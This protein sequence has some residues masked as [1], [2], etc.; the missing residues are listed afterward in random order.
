MPTPGR[1]RSRCGPVNSPR[2]PRCRRRLGRTLARMRARMENG[3]AIAPW[4]HSRT[5]TT[6]GSACARRPGRGACRS[7]RTRR[8]TRSIS[9]RRRSPTISSSR[10]TG[11]NILRGGRADLAALRVH[12]AIG[13]TLRALAPVDAEVAA[14]GAD[15]VIGRAIDEAGTPAPEPAV[16]AW[17]RRLDAQLA[18][19]ARR[20]TQSLGNPHLSPDWRKRLSETPPAARIPGRA[21]VARYLDWAARW[22]RHGRGMPGAQAVRLRP[23]GDRRV[24]RRSAGAC[25]RRR[26][27]RDARRPP[28]E[29]SSRRAAP[30][31]PSAR[32]SSTWRGAQTRCSRAWRRR[33]RPCIRPMP[34]SN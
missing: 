13:G 28:R 31:G 12:V 32:I 26:A 24:A 27:R 17:G 16:E 8:S 20:V 11:R 21:A 33:R 6:T 29:N 14:A 9:G 10:T 4:P 7:V 23:P 22:R 30:A 18:D 2:A 15:A 5:G 19:L 34:G 1:P 25:A 3:G